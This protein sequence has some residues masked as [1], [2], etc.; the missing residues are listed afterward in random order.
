[1]PIDII[2]QLWAFSLSAARAESS[3]RQEILKRKSG[4]EMGAREKSYLEVSGAS[5][6]KVKERTLRNQATMR[7]A[8]DS[9]RIA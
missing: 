6:K 5:R 9:T 7:S 3:E 2:L 8:T 4:R 1:M